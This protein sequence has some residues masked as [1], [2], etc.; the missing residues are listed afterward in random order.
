MINKKIIEA[1]IEQ[2]LGRCGWTHKIQEKQAD[3]YHNN[4]VWTECIR[5]G[6]SATLF[7]FAAV[8]SSRS[9]F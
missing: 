6:I 7:L 9:V 3:T 1:E 8:R 2:L 5:I 4:R